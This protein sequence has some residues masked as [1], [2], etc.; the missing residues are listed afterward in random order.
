MRVSL[1][2]ADQIGDK[3]DQLA[4]NGSLT[5]SFRRTRKTER[6]SGESPDRFGG[7]R[8]TLCACN[9]EGAETTSAE[10]IDC[11]S[12]LPGSLIDVETKSRHY[13]IE[14]LGGYAIRISGH[15]EYC[16]DPVAAHLHGSVNKEGTLELGLIGRGMRLIFLLNERH[17]ITTSKVLHVHVDQRQA[18][19]P[20]SSPSIQ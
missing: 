11:K 6:G 9:I 20:A 1:S 14:C 10:F 19:Q 16:P 5:A 18:A 7:A 8:G 12:L 13:Q 2:L 15:P 3:L 17:P 4:T